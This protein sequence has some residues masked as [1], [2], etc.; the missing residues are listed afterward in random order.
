M[1]R[2]RTLCTAPVWPMFIGFA[3]SAPKAVRPPARGVRQSS[4]APCI[5]V[6]RSLSADTCPLDS[7]CCSREHST[8]SSSGETL[9]QSL[10]QKACPLPFGHGI[11][12][13]AILARAV[14]L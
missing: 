11:N 4:G 5:H 3:S 2:V 14:A 10:C 12:E 9:S 8:L 7:E 1:G 6:R 13:A